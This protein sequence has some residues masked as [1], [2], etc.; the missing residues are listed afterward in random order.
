MERKRSSITTY[1]LTR[2]VGT[3]QGSP[4]YTRTLRT[5]SDDELLGWLPDQVYRIKRSCSGKFVATISVLR[6]EPTL[7][8]SFCI[9]QGAPEKGIN[10]L[11]AAVGAY[12]NISMLRQQTAD[13]VRMHGT[14]K[15]CDQWSPNGEC[16]VKYH[17]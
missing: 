15:G 1:V 2:R 4:W 16:C 9:L 10:A 14:I 3:S 12:V 6:C 11:D 5:G 8:L 7:N 13:R 17:L